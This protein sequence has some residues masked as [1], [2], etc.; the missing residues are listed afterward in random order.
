M[1]VNKLNEAVSLLKAGRLVAFPTETV[2]GLGADARN[3]LA[4]ANIFRAK[5]RPLHHPLIVHL[6]EFKQV[7][8]WVSEVSPVAQCLAE[9]FW[10]GPLTLIL[11]KRADVLDIVTG[12]QPSIGVRIPKHPMAQ[13]LLKA[14]GSGVAAPS[15]NLFTHVSPTTA[16]AVQEEL[17]AAVDLIL[18]GGECEVGLESTIIDLSQGAPRLLRPGMLTKA[19]LEE[20]IGQTI[21]LPDGQTTPRAPGMH[22][23]HYAP[24]TPAQ[25]ITTLELQNWSDLSQIAVIA[26][27]L[28][29]R[30]QGNALKW[31]HLGTDP[32]R[33]AHDLY[34]T[35]RELDHLAPRLILIE[36]VPHLPAWA[37]I[38]DRLSKACAR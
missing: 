33:Y 34:R 26:T 16:A 5:Q 6:H 22:P 25:L 3:E 7:K 37:A 17:G 30:M 14:F 15:A 12:D 1:S 35:L 27:T 36:T 13:A 31:V 18:D 28:P 21:F 38:A 23:V 19:I 9:A 8:D 20:T 11:P 2:Y 29:A 24:L 4:V 10:P 32:A